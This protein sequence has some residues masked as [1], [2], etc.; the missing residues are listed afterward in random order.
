ML[1][2]GCCNRYI[3][4][5]IVF[6]KKRL[7]NIIRHPDP[8][9]QCMCFLKLP[10]RNFTWTPVSDFMLQT[11]RYT[12]CGLCAYVCVCVCVLLK[13][14]A[15]HKKP[16]HV[17]DCGSVNAY[18][19][20][21]GCCLK[22]IWPYMETFLPRLV[23]S[24]ANAVNVDSKCLQ[25]VLWTAQLRRAQSLCCCCFYCCSWHIFCVFSLKVPVQKHCVQ[26]QSNRVRDTGDNN[27]FRRHCPAL[28]KLHLI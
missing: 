10:C 25:V 18:V 11:C 13:R 21:S 26:A 28:P 5:Y 24:I 1:H 8:I 2:I 7:T 16:V 20:C 27:V 23:C 3:A 14:C 12:C 4:K 19:Y 9:N 22:S 15:S 17:C 6:L